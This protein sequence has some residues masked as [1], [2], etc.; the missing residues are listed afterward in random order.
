MRLDEQA[1]DSAP[2]GWN[3]WK[4]GTRYWQAMRADAKPE[5]KGAWGPYRTSAEDALRDARKLEQGE[6]IET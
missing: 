5:S 2:T 6:G 4:K 3:I 1:T